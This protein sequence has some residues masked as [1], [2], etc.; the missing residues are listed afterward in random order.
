MTRRQERETKF[1]PRRRNV[2]G[3]Q[4]GH[5]Q[6][7]FPAENTDNYTWKGGD[8]APDGPAAGTVEF[9][10]VINKADITVTGAVEYKAGHTA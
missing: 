5:L 3:D 8:A 1:S 10:W 9:T 7:N 6:Y 2:H 4:C